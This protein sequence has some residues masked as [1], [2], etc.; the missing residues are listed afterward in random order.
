ANVALVVRL[1]T[2]GTTRSS[3]ASRTRRAAG[4][5]VPRRAASGAGRGR[6]ITFR[7]RRGNI[8][9]LGSEEKRKVPESTGLGRANVRGVRT[10]FLKVLLLEEGGGHFRGS[11]NAHFYVCRSFN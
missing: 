1:R 7:G 11:R 10:L 8:W 9:H 2:T 6:P 3:S 5:R 4:R